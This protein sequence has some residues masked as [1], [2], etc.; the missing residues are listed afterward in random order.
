MAWYYGSD[1]STSGFPT[2]K[3]AEPP[4]YIGRIGAGTGGFENREFNVATANAAAPPQTFGYWDLEGPGNTPGSMTNT[5]WGTAQA[6][7]FVEAWQTGAYCEY[8]GGRTFFLDSESGNSGWNVGTETDRQEILIGALDYL[9]NVDNVINEPGAAGVYT[10]P[11]T[12]T[13][14]FGSYTSPYPFVF[15]YAGTDSP[16]CTQA[17]T[18][19]STYPQASVGGWKTM[20]WQFQASNATDFD[21]TPYEGYWLNG[22]WKP[23]QA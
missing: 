17:Q 19:F 6:Q 3:G 22:Y 20:I 23:V 12:W 10:S 14:F 5:Q 16:D 11:D 4:F 2:C 9:S 15:W 18:Q 7:A 1:G 13:S 21:I 8:V